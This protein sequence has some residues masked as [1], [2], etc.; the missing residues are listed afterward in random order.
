MGTVCTANGGET[1]FGSIALGMQYA[2]DRG[3]SV[4]NGTHV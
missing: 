4:S 1:S 2:R 3:Y